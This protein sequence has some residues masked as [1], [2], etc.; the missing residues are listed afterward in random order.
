MFEI[1]SSSTWLYNQ[2]KKKTKTNSNKIGQSCI[3]WCDLRDILEKFESRSTTFWRNAKQKTWIK[4][5]KSIA[6]RR[7]SNWHIVVKMTSWHWI[8][9]SCI[10]AVQC[11]IISTFSNQTDP[12]YTHHHA[13]HTDDV[14]IRCNKSLPSGTLT[15]DYIYDDGDSVQKVYYTSRE[16]DTPGTEGKYT[17]D[18]ATRDITIHNVTAL[19]HGSYM[20][21]IIGN[22]LPL[23]LDDYYH[24]LSIYGKPVELWFD[25]TCMV[26]CAVCCLVNY[27]VPTIEL[28]CFC[29][30]L[31]FYQKRLKFRHSTWASIALFMRT[32]WPLYSVTFRLFTQWTRCHLNWFTMDITMTQATMTPTLNIN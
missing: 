28:L 18:V 13:L 1:Q 25:H 31:Q 11:V 24:F 32:P 16:L 15:L 6:V 7:K 27:S 26:K 4:I 14:T 9:M 5:N 20:C 21:R 10:S 23:T 2:K 29:F 17:V 12:T 8:I 3:T 19:D 30:Q 22:N